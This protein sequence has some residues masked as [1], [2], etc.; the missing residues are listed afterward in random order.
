MAP[1]SEVREEPSRIAR[2]REYLDVA[3]SL[4]DGPL[5]RTREWS[6]CA[7]VTGSTAYGRP[8]AG[9]DLDLFVV[10]RSGGLWWFLA[11]TYFMLRLE[12]WKGA[13]PR[14]PTTCFN[15]VI[16]HQAAA[17]EFSANRGFLFAREALAAQPVSG[18]RY[19]RALLARGDWMRREVP[20][21]YDEQHLAAE[22]PTPE[23]D[24]APYAVRALSALVYPWLAAYLQLVGLRRNRALRNGGRADE[25][26]RTETRWRRLT[27]ASRKF[28]ELREALGT[29]AVAPA[30]S[31]DRA[32]P[33]TCS[34]AVR[35]PAHPGPAG[36]AS[37]SAVS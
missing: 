27:F 25:R 28:E 35:P 1:H 30:R 15:F 2:G 36:N 19:Y 10:T 11:Y 29:P 14:E 31:S 17:A 37:G 7:C 20:R 23:A 9:D 5:R 4:F 3:R 16:D 18:E 6:H 8:R 34:E 22:G 26:F 33:L 12:R 24:A 21:L 32:P 13:T